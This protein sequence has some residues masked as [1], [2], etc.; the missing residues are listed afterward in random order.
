MI[1]HHIAGALSCALFVTTLLPQ[2]ESQQPKERN[3]QEKTTEK[4][5]TEDSHL[6]DAL[7]QWLVN[8]NKAE[9][10]LGKLA[11]EKASSPDVKEFAQMMVK[12]H[13]AF[14]AKVEKFTDEKGQ[15]VAGADRKTF[16]DPTEEKR[17]V[18]EKSKESQP[19][20]QQVGYRGDKHAAMEKIGKRA[21]EIELQM[22]KDLLNTFQ[23]HE[24]DMAYVGQQ[25]AGH[26]KMLA[27]L[28]AM[29]EGTSGEFQAVVKQG[30]KTAEMHLNHAK[31]L[32]AQLQ[33]Q[34]GAKTGA[35]TE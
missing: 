20:E 31:E 24:F 29:E 8:G 33:K 4:V 6:T 10:E 23:G 11:S 32:S 12:D 18:T 34:G 22:T 13:S 15:P 3:A 2:A 7:A 27:T 1:F 16:E 17:P 21:G 30:V 19:K 14:L 26:T 9:I 5:T 28:K 35:R 25:I